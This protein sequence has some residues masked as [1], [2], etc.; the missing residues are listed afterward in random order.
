PDADGARARRRRPLLCRRDSNRRDHLRGRRRRTTRGG[1][2]RGASG[3]R[4]G[5]ALF[6]WMPTPAGL[7]PA[8]PP[9]G[10][11]VKNRS[12]R[13]PLG[14]AMGGVFAAVADWSGAR[15]RS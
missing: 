13:L 6:F 2:A 4:G 12:A 9:G 11:R 5:V 15:D 7:R 10:E 14:R 3:T 1:R 8:T